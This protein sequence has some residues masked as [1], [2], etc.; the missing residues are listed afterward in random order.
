MKNILCS[1][2]V[3][4]IL[5]SCREP[6]ARRP[7]SVK[8]GTTFIQESIDRNKQLLAFEEEQIRTIIERDTVHTYISSPNGYSY[9]YNIKNESANYYPKT[10]DVIKLSY[11][12]R[13]IDDTIIYAKEDVGEQTIK[14]DK[15]ELF[16]GLRT[17]VKL[18]K[19]GE[20]MTF[21]FPSA[22]A[23]GYHGDNNKIG[24]NVPIICTVTLLDIVEIAE[25]TN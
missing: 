4:L 19:E 21:V 5:I 15:V 2:S 8:T 11:E 14:V 20:T 18:I 17:A 22:L 1:L 6:Q 16:P 3:L 7:V 9:Y 25:G 13:T 23:H 12:I 10:D 24:T